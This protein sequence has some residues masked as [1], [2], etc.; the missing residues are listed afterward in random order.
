MAKTL[1][2]FKVFIVDT[3]TAGTPD[4][5]KYSGVVED[6]TGFFDS[7]RVKGV[8]DPAPADTKTWKEVYNETLAAVKT[9][10]GIS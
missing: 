4:T 5:V 2:E 6:S 3:E 10:H 8:V 7:T 1:K 9:E